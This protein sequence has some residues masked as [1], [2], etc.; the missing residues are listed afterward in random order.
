MVLPMG[1]VDRKLELFEN[2]A[3]LRRVGRRVPGNPELATV[4]AALERELGETVSQRL[5]ARV[6][7]V[8]HTA[9][10]RWIAAGDLPLVYST[11][12]RREVPV[13]ALLRLQEAVGEQA[14]RS[15]RYVLTPTMKGQR[16]AAQRMRM[17][18][19]REPGSH[20]R[21][22]ARSLAY[23]RALARKLRKSMV[24]EA[25]HVLFRWRVEGKIDAHYAEQWERVLNQPMAE[26][27]KAI[28]EEG[29]GADDLRQN[30]PLAG[31]LSEAERRRIVKE[32]H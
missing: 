18:D 24:E 14:K 32:V 4:R 11:R 8:S 22:H 23:H 3:R 1:I 27:R 25:K 10:Q 16:N 30:S 19:L 17:K 6:L 9:L 29:Q 7:G 15:G 31:L 12:G 20:A 2:I 21:A 5:A 13:S 28:V 26:I